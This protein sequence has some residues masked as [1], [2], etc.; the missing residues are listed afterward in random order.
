MR[1][2][3]SLLWIGSGRGLS[4]SGM[5]EA[6]ELDV[7][8]VP[9]VDEALMLPAVRFD[10]VLLELEEPEALELALPD[11]DRFAERRGILVTTNDAS[12]SHA[13]ALLAMGVGAVFVLDP[14]GGSRGFVSEVNETLDALQVQRSANPLPGGPARSQDAPRP[15]SVS[16]RSRLVPD[17]EGGEADD[18]P[19]VIGRSEGMR[20]VSEFV[21]LAAPSPSTVLV[22]GETGVGKEVIARELHARGTR[23]SHP[24]V[25]I[26]CAAFPEALLESEL[27]GHT[28]G[29][30]TGA[31]ADKVGLFE[32]AGDGTL[33]LDEIAETN[34]SLQAKLLR[35]LQE[36]EIRPVGD[37]AARPITCRIVAATNRDLAAEVERGHFRED[38]FYR[39]NVF[40][41]RIPPLRERRADVLPLARSFLSLHGPREGKHGCHLSLAASHLLEAYHWPGNVR[42]LEN[43]IKRALVLSTDEVLAPGEF[44]FLESPTRDEPTGTSLEELVT[45]EVEE[46]LSDGSEQSEIYREIQERIDRP[47]I[48]VVLA[49]TQGN[50]IRAAALLGINRNTLRKKITEL[51]IELPKRN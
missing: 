23:D 42:E 29:A 20:R 45:R 10:A 21:D 22:T 26:N 28:K 36:R 39:L 4:G 13:D 37:V 12:P 6:P 51:E 46:L 33:F 40:P 16:T 11:L 49:R 1:T 47:L 48:Q 19:R 15:A 35:V 17:R 32:A 2:I 9:N 27:F 8:W 41:I 30:F 44:D 7:T 24:F 18:L 14:A 31:N 34:L 3:R 5:T 43:A 38:L 25:A 50:Q